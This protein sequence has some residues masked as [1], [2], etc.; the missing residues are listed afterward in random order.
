MLALEAWPL[1]AGQ[2]ARQDRNTHQDAGEDGEEEAEAD[3][4]RIAH[5]LAQ[6]RGV[7]EEGGRAVCAA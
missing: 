3:D 6:R 2:S 4:D 1:L 5:A 7:V